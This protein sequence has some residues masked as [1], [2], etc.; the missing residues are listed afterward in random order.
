MLYRTADYGRTWHSIA[1]GLPAG[2]FARVL[3]EDPVERGLLY[4]GTENGLFISFDDGDHW[5]PFQLNFPRVP[6]TDLKVHAGD[7]VASTEGRAFW[8]LDDLSSLEQLAAQVAQVKSAGAYLFKPRKAYLLDRRGGP[9]AL[10]AGIGTDSPDGAVIRYELGAAPADAS[11]Q[12]TLEILDG[13]GRV[14]RTFTSQPVKHEARSLV[15]GVIKLPPARPVPAKPG[16]NAYLWDLRVAPYTPVADTIRYVSQIPYRVSPGVYTVRLTY[17]GRSLTQSFEVAND[18]RHEPVTAAQWAEQQQLLARLGAMVDDIHDCA[19][20]MRAIAQ[21]AQAMMRRAATNPHADGVERSGHAL[22]A[23]IARWEEQVP[24]PKLPDDA[25]D[26]VSFPSRL[27]STPVL[28]LIAMVDQDPP[29]TAAAQDE[30]RD[31][32]ARW[33]SSRAQMGQI[34]EHELAAFATQLRKAGLPAEL[35]P[36]RPGSPPPPRVDD[37]RS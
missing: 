20:D 18:P 37:S 23:A 21:Q 29:V 17:G 14:I 8:I 26:F 27:L 30:A 12:V 25:Q 19:N 28:N 4:A 36:W 3:R 7:L 33:S 11:K 34:K 9:P 15:K 13:S 32:Q 5:Q 35:R 31:L 6:V 24:Q 2:V 22:I 1:A 16:M 10:Q